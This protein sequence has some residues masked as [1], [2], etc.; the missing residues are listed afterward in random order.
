MRPYKHLL[1]WTIILL[2]SFSADGSRLTDTLR[3]MAVGEWR[4]FPAPAADP[5]LFRSINGKTIFSY[6][7][8]GVWDPG[9]QQVLFLGAFYGT[10]CTFIGYDA[11]ADRWSALPLPP[12]AAD[13]DCSRTYHHLAIDAD[14]GR[15][16][17]RL[18]NSAHVYCYR[19]RTR[20]WT[21][22]PPD[23]LAQFAGCCG[24]I[25]Y[26]R[27][28]GGLVF[29]NGGETKKGAGLFLYSDNSGA[30]S[31]LGQDLPMGDQM[32][33]A[34]YNPVYGQVI[35]GGGFSKTLYRLS[36]DGGVDTLRPAPYNLGITRSLMFADPVTGDYQVLESGNHHLLYHP[37]AET[38]DTLTDSVPVFFPGIAPS[39]EKVVAVPMPDLGAAFFIWDK[40]SSA[41]PAFY[42]CKYAAVVSV[43]TSRRRPFTDAGISVRPNPFHAVAVIS[44][45][46]PEQ[47]GISLEV[48]DFRGR[49]LSC[50]SR[51]I[52]GAGDYRFTWNRAGLPAGI[53]LCRLVAGSRVRV[54]K[55]ILVN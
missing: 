26:F 40:D 23:T 10:P 49:V 11:E 38:W 15:M 55:A 54:T 31:R 8:R 52:K 25:E 21:A 3:R 5:S 30:W 12:F 27:E 14:S 1:L 13:Y 39:L 43:E 16:F 48:L 44:F 37:L 34:A 35:F 41:S 4:V 51:G 24:A 36:A 29:V 28:M 19:A 33:F 32:N 47:A 6:T 9:T 7:D 46:L 50:L 45:H 20:T 2:V 22:L 42:L 53:Y 17:Y 18:G